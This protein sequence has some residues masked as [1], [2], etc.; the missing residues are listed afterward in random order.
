MEKGEA[1]GTVT[2][3]GAVKVAAYAIHRNLSE[4]KEKRGERKKREREKE[5]RERR[6]RERERGKMIW[7]GKKKQ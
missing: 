6:E 4:R 3:K 1:A 5:E 7:K 2:I